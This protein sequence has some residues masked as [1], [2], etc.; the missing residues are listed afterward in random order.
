MWDQC[1]V[2]AIL[3]KVR[4]QAFHGFR[5]EREGKMFVSMRKAQALADEVRRGN[6]C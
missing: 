5:C 6:G 2:G 1:N 3:R 4:L